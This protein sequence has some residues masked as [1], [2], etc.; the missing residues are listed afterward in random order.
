VLYIVELQNGKLWKRH[1]NQLREDRTEK[2]EDREGN[3][4]MN[5]NENE[6]TFN[7]DD[8]NEEEKIVEVNKRYPTRIRKENQ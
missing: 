1:I 6:N 3:K 4:E 7:I 5:L 8:L 2:E